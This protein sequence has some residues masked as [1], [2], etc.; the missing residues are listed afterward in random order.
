MNKIN[1]RNCGRS[2]V[3]LGHGV[4]VTNKCLSCGTRRPSIKIK[5]KSPYDGREVVFVDSGGNDGFTN[6]NTFTAVATLHHG[7][8]QLPLDKKANWIFRIILYLAGIEYRKI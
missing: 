2:T 7:Q 4:V 8:V 1:C 6:L 3:E 5:N